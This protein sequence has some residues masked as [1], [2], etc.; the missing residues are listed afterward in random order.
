MASLLF[1]LDGTLIDSSEDI[2][3]CLK[4]SIDMLNIDLNYTINNRY[5]GPPLIEVV[6]NILPNI[7]EEINKQISINFRNLYDNHSLSKTILNKNCLETISLLK[8]NGNELYIVTNKPLKPTVKI[9]RNL[10]IDKF[11]TDIFSPDSLIKRSLTKIEM[12]SILINKYN[13]AKSNAFIIG[14]TVSDISAGMQVGIN[15]VAYCAGYGDPIELKKC[16][17]SFFIHDLYKI[18]TVI[19]PI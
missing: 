13:I 15:T 8:K 5:L 17:P 14:D 12:I 7:S 6:K 3:D 2:I 18:I 19:E 11:F 16:K 10:S 4:K 9:L 1:D